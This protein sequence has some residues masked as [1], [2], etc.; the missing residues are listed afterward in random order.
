MSKYDT[1]FV[2]P[3]EILLVYGIPHTVNGR[4]KAGIEI[5]VRHVSIKAKPKDSFITDRTEM[6]F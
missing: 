5:W 2:N 3:G 4:T 1:N 6:N